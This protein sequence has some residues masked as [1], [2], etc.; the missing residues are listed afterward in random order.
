MLIKQLISS[1]MLFSFV[2]C[3]SDIEPH[4]IPDICSCPKSPLL[5]SRAWQLCPEC[6]EVQYVHVSRSQRI[7]LAW[8][9]QRFQASA[10]ELDSSPSTKIPTQDY[11]SDKDN[12]DNIP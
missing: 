6:S 7:K 4:H 2:S 9:T 5:R 3:D 11:N 1:P 8:E 10:S 12:F